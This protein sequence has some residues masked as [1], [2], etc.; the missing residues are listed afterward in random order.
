MKL[1][2]MIR[3]IP[4]SQRFK[5]MKYYTSRR[6]LKI[7]IQHR[8]KIPSLMLT[9]LSEK[10]TYYVSF[11]LCGMSRR[12]KFAEAESRIWLLNVG[13]DKGFLVQAFSVR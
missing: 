12:G 11:Y 2:R 1:E 3:F 10:T 7:N 6:G 8:G 4:G 5:R 9:R 13:R